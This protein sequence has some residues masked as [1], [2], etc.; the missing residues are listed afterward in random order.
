MKPEPVYEANRSD[1][2]E[3]LRQVLS[4]SAEISYH[5]GKDSATTLI[6]IVALGN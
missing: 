4:S 5:S 1:S 2:Q 3:E 6:I